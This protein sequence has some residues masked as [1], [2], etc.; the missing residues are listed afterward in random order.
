MKKLK[1][2]T[3]II[4]ISIFL[5]INISQSSTSTNLSSHFSSSFTVLNTKNLPSNLTA[6]QIKEWINN[7]T[8]YY[9]SSDAKNDTFYKTLELKSYEFNT[10][11]I[12]LNFTDIEPQNLTKE[13]ETSH[14]ELG[15]PPPNEDISVKTYPRLMSFRIPRTCY[16][17]SLEITLKVFVIFQVTVDWAI[18]N[19]TELTIQTQSYPYPNATLTTG[20]ITM[21]VS[22]TQYL[23]LNITISPPLLLNISKTYDNTFFLQI[24]AQSL[25]VNEDVWWLTYYD[26]E[27]G[28]T[29]TDGV[30]EGYAYRYQSGTFVNED[31]DYFLQY[32]YLSPLI[33]SFQDYE[34]KVNR[35][36]VS[37]DRTWNSTNMI[38]NDPIF[39]NITS[40]WPITFNVTCES[41]HVKKELLYTSCLVD[42]N[43]DNVTW[44]VNSTYTFPSE[45][46]NCNTS[47]YIPSDWIL[48]NSTNNIITV[49]ENLITVSMSTSWILIFQGINYIE[50]IDHPANV[51]INNE[52]EFLTQWNTTVTVSNGNLTIAIYNTSN[53]KIYEETKNVTQGTNFTWTPINVEKGEYKVAMLFYNGTEVGYRTSKFQVL[54]TMKIEVE[55]LDEY[56]LTGENITI[57]VRCIDNVTGENITDVNVY[58]TWIKGTVQ[59]K[60]N[61][62]NGWYEGVFNTSELVAG[63]YNISIYVSKEYYEKTNVNITLNLIYP[64]KVLPE[65]QTYEG[66]YLTPI[67]LTIRYTHLNGTI[68]T[69]ANIYTDNFTFSFNGTTYFYEFLPEKI[70][71][72]R[73]KVYC[74]KPLHQSQEAYIIIEVHALRT[75]IE[76]SWNEKQIEYPEEAQLYVRYESNGTGIPN[77]TCIVT[78]TLVNGSLTSLTY[79]T[80]ESGHIVLNISPNLFT[81]DIESNNVTGQHVINIY[82]SKYGYESQELNVTL[83]ILSKTAEAKVYVPLEINIDEPLRIEVTFNYSYTFIPKLNQTLV[84]NFT[85]TDYSNGTIIY[86]F[87]A[88]GHGIQELEIT[89][90]PE[91]PNIRSIKKKFSV[92]IYGKLVI[93]MPTI[94]SEYENETLTFQI[95]I[96]DYRTKKPVKSNVSIYVDDI[97]I[98]DIVTTAK[99]NT[100]ISLIGFETGEHIL[101][102]E[103]TS[104]FYREAEK[105][106]QLTILPKIPTMITTEVPSEVF[107]EENVIIEISLT[108]IN[109]TAIP[110]KKLI[111]TLKFTYLNGT[112][113]EWS[114][115]LVTNSEGKAFYS[116]KS[117]TTGNLT[118]IAYFN[119]SRE[120]L[121]SQSEEETVKILTRVSPAPLW[122]KLVTYTRQYVEEITI[123]VAVFLLLL[124][125]FIRRRRFTRHILNE[126]NNLASISNI[127]EILIVEKNSGLPIRDFK[128]FSREERSPE[129]IA[130]FI[131]AVQT[132]YVE[133]SGKTGY[134]DEISYGEPEPRVLT[135]S[136]GKYVYTIAISTEKL[137]NKEIIR[138]ITRRFEEMY[139]DNLRNWGGDL[140]SFKG[141]EKIIYSVFGKENLAIY[142]PININK[143][144]KALIKLIKKISFQNN[145]FFIPRLVKELEKLPRSE[146]IKLYKQLLKLKKKGKLLKMEPDL[147]KM[148][149]INL[150]EPQLQQ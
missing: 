2:F 81:D 131:Q 21:T 95:T 23:Q 68:I 136:V 82:I 125:F 106:A 60:Y 19:A 113:K 80:N 121:P 64:T 96:L 16:L 117:Q 135:C 84:T 133:L 120:Y 110:D 61:E 43:H 114:K 42:A 89:I 65:I 24:S 78:Y 112:T 138:E 57:R 33:R 32:V 88:E 71:T 107:T 145:L 56:Y 128:I 97:W 3:A 41:S 103:A 59:F 30:D 108:D 44:Y 28:G 91:N 29:P 1:F 143:T 5:L 66:Y 86:S 58:A 40:S 20:T 18:I 70:G 150:I 100:S 6:I 46:S 79:Y 109:G 35:T 111:L 115:T 122:S 73:F 63:I 76:Y 51:T 52:I 4:I 87:Y 9:R 92:T 72:F 12:T 149:R 14:P 140:S 102:V 127:E 47:F 118:V 124:F 34:L 55:P 126:I 104:L 31:V 116:F 85:K 17:T 134:L 142:K 53:V 11:K 101:K 38:T 36:L 99:V 27:L 123:I 37:E 119:G 144:P 39:L 48:Q 93:L 139:K 22:G 146:K 137:K 77:A 90:V 148:E 49:Q 26:P 50:S 25:S 15:D 94:L 74:E 45:F 83:T 141:A 7:E 147:V 132:F 10:T 8:E 98:R 105:I 130:G 67:N 54:Y 13:I 69:D 129:L 62:S 75:E